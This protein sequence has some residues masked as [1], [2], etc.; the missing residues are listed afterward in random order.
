MSDD[1]ESN[2]VL[3]VTGKYTK[4]VCT[5]WYFVLKHRWF[6]TP[7]IVA[8]RLA[9]G[10]VALQVSWIRLSIGIVLHENADNYDL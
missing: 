7:A 3:L 6:L 1:I 2:I 5:F 8:Y 10:S 4:G 9:G